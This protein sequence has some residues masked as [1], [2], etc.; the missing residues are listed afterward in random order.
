MS[1]ARGGAS[2]G[3]AG[4]AA[5]SM[6]ARS[7]EFIFFIRY[8]TSPWSSKTWASNRVSRAAFVLLQQ[9]ILN[10]EVMDD[11]QYFLLAKRRCLFE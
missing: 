2:G 11:G 4:I 1:G 6:G 10:S 3:A 5:A 8:V 9:S 7:F